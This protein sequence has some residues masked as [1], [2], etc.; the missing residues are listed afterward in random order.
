MHL[1]ILIVIV[2][3]FLGFLSRKKPEF[4]LSISDGVISIEGGSIS[5][6]LLDD[7]TSALKKTKRGKVIAFRAEQ[8]LKLSFKGGVNEST[9]QRLKNIVG[10]HYR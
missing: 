7:F 9:A 4:V 2:C 5:N 6:G 3:L 1:L 10:I 8:G